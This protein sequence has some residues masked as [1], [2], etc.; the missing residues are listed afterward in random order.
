[1]PVTIEN[2]VFDTLQI[3]AIFSNVFHTDNTQKW[4]I[5]KHTWNPRVAG[6]SPGVIAIFNIEDSL[7]T[8]ISNTLQRFLQEDEEVS[9]VMYYEW[10]QLS[11][12]NWHNDGR[13]KAAITVYLNETWDP[14]FGGFFCWREDS[15]TARL[16]VP[17]FNSAVIVRGNPFHHVSLISP[18]APVRKTLQVWIREK[19]S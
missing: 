5:H 3:Q 12:I 16:F 13:K 7:R 4:R 11:Q 9:C 19:P 6:K 2:N 8:M 10:N 1:M 15:E 14:D 18:Y 17:Q